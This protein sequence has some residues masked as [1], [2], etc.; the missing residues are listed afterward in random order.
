MKN[1]SN[2]KFIWHIIFNKTRNLKKLQM[3]KTVELTALGQTKDLTELGVGW[4][5]TSSIL[6]KYLLETCSLV[7]EAQEQK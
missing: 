3:T 2:S 4:G 1:S 6:G 7:L 5:R